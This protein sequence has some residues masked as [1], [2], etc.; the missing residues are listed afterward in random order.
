M[1]LSNCKANAESH[2]RGGGEAVR[3]SVLP[4]M[5]S[6]CLV[7][8]GI[9]AAERIRLGCSTLFIFYAN[10]HS[11]WNGV[12]AYA[13][14]W[15]S[16]IALVLRLGANHKAIE[17]CQLNTAAAWPETTPIISSACSI[18]TFATSQTCCNTFASLHPKALPALATS[19]QSA[20]IKGKLAEDSAVLTSTHQ[21]LNYK[22][23]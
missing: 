18:C 16:P 17:E 2:W 10:S 11:T 21:R 20:D 3:I 8:Y 9:D 7:I 12:V 23:F 19:P 5:R 4:Q 15:L 13:Y 1:V 6:H 22:T 14:K